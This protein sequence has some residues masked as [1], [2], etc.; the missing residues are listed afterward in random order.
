LG[1]LWR[2]VKVIG[3]RDEVIKILGEIYIQVMPLSDAERYYYY[4]LTIL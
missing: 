2:S 1:H 4:E 3:K